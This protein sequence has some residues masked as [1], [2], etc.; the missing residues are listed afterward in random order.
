[1]PD[2]LKQ[3]ACS[4]QSASVEVSVMMAG[5]AL[6]VDSPFTSLL[7]SPAPF[8][9]FVYFLTFLGVCGFVM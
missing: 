1:M 6:P 7:H 4:T 2:S 8:P 3:P 5:A 9:R